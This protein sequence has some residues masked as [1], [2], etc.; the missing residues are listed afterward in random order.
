MRLDDGG[1]LRMTSTSSKQCELEMRHS[2][3]SGVNNISFIDFMTGTTILARIS[4]SGTNYSPSSLKDRLLIQNNINT[5][6]HIVFRTVTSGSGVD[7]ITIAN[8]GELRL[9][10]DNQK[11]VFGGGQDASI[12][13]DDTNMIIAPAEVGTGELVVQTS[14]AITGVQIDNTAVDGDPILSFAL[15]GTKMFTMGVDD[16]DGDKFKIGTSAIGTNTWM[17]VDSSQ[18]IGFGT[19]T[20][21][22]KVDVNGDI[23]VASSNAFYFG[24]IDADGSWRIVRSG[25]D[26]AFER[27]ESSSWVE[28]GA[29]VP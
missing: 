5:N 24:A 27:R 10:A 26:L 13:Y 18:N 2:A 21:T 14:G 1:L 23:K 25:D 22:V 12:Y 17:T 3:T 8:S 20:P 6:G 9:L 28:K 15:S 11:I 4:S 16:G 7:R 29:M 19:D